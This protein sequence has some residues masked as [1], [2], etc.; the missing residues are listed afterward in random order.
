MTEERLHGVLVW[1]VLSMAVLTFLFLLQKAA[2][3]GRHYTG[4]GWGPHVSDRLGWI[5]MELPAIVVCLAVYCNGKAAF[6]IVPLLFLAM[7][8][9]HYLHRTFLYPFRVR[10]RGRKM[11]L[12]VVGSGFFF[13]AIN[14]YTNARFI[15]EF[16]EYG[17]A[18]LTDPRFLIGVGIFLAGI[19]LNLHSDNTLIRLRR[20]GGTGY[21]IPQGGGFRLVSCPNYL[22]EILEWVGWAIATWSSSGLAFL[23]F[24]AANLVPRARSNHRWY[25]ETFKDYPAHR[26]ALI[27]RIY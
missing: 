10:A 7:W 24:T 18:W 25:L 3:Y 15:A 22:G 19:V 16:G 9:G 8:Q 21:A 14:A 2:P 20:P 17:I 26:R 13:N 5:V 27:P 6:Q 12:L 4:A 1:A 11:P 23:L